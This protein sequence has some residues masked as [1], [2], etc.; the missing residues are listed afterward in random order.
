MKILT[1]IDPCVFDGGEDA[2][3]VGKKYELI[4]EG[5]VEFSIKSE[6]SEEHW[7]EYTDVSVLAHW[8]RR[9]CRR[10]YS[11]ERLGPGAHEVAS[12]RE[13]NIYAPVACPPM[14]AY[15][16]PKLFQYLYKYKYFYIY[17]YIGIIRGMIGAKRRGHILLM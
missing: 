15:F 6:V 13:R 14:A 8:C 3:I 2:L 17:V 7:F 9:G 1:A 16:P 10:A 11:R 12:V 5:T 4:F